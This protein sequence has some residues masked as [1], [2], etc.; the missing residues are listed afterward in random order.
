MTRLAALLAFSFVV[1]L[2]VGAASSNPS[3]KQTGVSAASWEV[4]AV[5]DDWGV[6]EPMTPSEPRSDTPP[7]GSEPPSVLCCC[8]T[9]NG[10]CCAEVTFCGGF[11]PGCFC[12]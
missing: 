6:A 12:S 1:L 4:E 2:F 10:Q 11:I 8:N 3:T 5:S 9:R 7:P